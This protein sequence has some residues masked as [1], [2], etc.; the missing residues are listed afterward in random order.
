MHKLLVLLLLVSTNIWSQE[1]GAYLDP[2]Y[3]DLKH[4]VVDIVRNK[5]ISQSNTLYLISKSTP[6]KSQGSRGT[7]SI[8]SAISIL[9]TMMVLK[10]DFTT[11]LDLSEE[12]LEYLVVRNR[13][14]DGSNSYRNFSAISR[15]GIPFEKTLPYI[16]D[17]WSSNPWYPMAVQRCGHLVDAKKESCLII[18]RDPSLLDKSDAE[19]L[20]ES[21][22]L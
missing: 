8:F 4:P 1:D 21:S 19:L 11:E 13:T 10:H 14:S 12:Y 7:C 6:I 9:E 15:Y 18:H 22:P 3:K 17:N 2:A 5:N 20:D 16:G